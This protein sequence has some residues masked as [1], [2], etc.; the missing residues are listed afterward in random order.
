M[1][2]KSTLIT[3]ISIYFAIFSFLIINQSVAVES[4]HDYKQPSTQT[5]IFKKNIP[6]PEMT[7][8]GRLLFF[9]IRLSGDNSMS[10]A[11]CHRPDAYWSDGQKTATGLNNKSL[12]LSTPTIINAA[13]NNKQ[14]WDGR[15]NSL[16]QQSTIPI[17]SPDEMNQDMDLLVKELK[18]ISGYVTL[19]DQA[20]GSKGIT[21]PN[22]SRALAAFQRT[23]ISN[24]TPFDRWYAGDESAISASAKRGFVLFENKARCANC[25]SG[26]NF[27]DSKFHN[28][29]LVSGKV[30]EGRYKISKKNNHRGA[31]KTPTLR[32]IMKTAPYMHNGTY[33]TIEEVIAHY[34]RG[35]NGIENADSEIRKLH[36]SQPEIED[37]IAFLDTLNEVVS[38]KIP[39]H[40]PQ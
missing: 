39:H 14:F 31:F 4:L 7:N 25:H 35:G 2:F 6:T 12:K 33:E 38:V 27:N 19:F 8:L 5:Y 32:N 18:A 34:N 11:T 17:Q 40:F 24:N 13:Y 21:R 29:G 36:L 1:P 20:F 10:C 37:L 3:Q 22:I 9:D 28:I 30:Q 16:E 23:I 15:V 26:F